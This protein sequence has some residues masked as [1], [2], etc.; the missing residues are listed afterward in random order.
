MWAGFLLALAVG[1]FYVLESSSSVSLCSITG[2]QDLSFVCPMKFRDLWLPAHVWYQRL[3]GLIDGCG[4]GP[5]AHSQTGM[6]E[7]L[8]KSLLSEAYPTMSSMPAWLISMSWWWKSNSQSTLFLAQKTDTLR[9]HLQI[10]LVFLDS[11]VTHGTPGNL[12]E[13]FC[14]W[15]CPVWN[16][17]L[18]A[19]QEAQSSQATPS[20]LP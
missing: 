6:L 19:K 1:P 5:K 15:R 11:T 4:K 17:S 14:G 18:K 20:G 7:L 3:V 13:V 12:L 9:S 10:F 2:P 8:P 16:R